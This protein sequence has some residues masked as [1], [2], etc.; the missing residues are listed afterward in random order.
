MK[1]RGPKASGG[2]ANGAKTFPVTKYLS[3]GVNAYDAIEVPVAV[4]ALSL[5]RKEHF[6]P[7]LAKCINVRSISVPPGGDVAFSIPT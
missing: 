5:N 2:N 3:G 4:R 1:A 6:T 7:S